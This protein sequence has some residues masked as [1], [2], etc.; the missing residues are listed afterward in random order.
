MPGRFEGYRYFEGLLKLVCI[1][2][3][4]TKHE[5][6]QIPNEGDVLIHAGD[7]SY[8]GTLPETQKFLDWFAAQPQP[9]K[10][11]VPGNHDF[12]FEENPTLAL[13]MCNER[14]ITLLDNKYAEHDGVKFYG[15]P[16]TPT[17]GDWAMMMTHWE[18]KDYWERVTD[19]M[20]VLITHGPPYKVL[21][22][23]PGGGFAGCRYHREAIERLK[24]DVCIFGH[25][26]LGG[27]GEY[28]NDSIRYYNVA[29]LDERYVVV[30]PPRII[31]L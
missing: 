13:E 2:D 16:M 12:L 10:I 30:N 24:P 15:C 28:V 5:Q 26:H 19:R 6:I 11:L 17:F 7:Y 8:R 21:D 3:T 4:H 27:G 31:E 23:V 14:N 9:N 1:S 18:S 20:N 29:C 25:I 22:R